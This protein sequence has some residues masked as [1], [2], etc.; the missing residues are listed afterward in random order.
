MVLQHSNSG[1]VEYVLN[2]KLHLNHV[3]IIAA[4]TFN[5]STGHFQIL[6]HPCFVEMVLLSLVEQRP[7]IRITKA[8]T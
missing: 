2:I 6:N 8:E 1:S 4:N 3:A 7:K 5:N